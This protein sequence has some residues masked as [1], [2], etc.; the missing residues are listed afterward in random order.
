MSIVKLRP[1]VV[2]SFCHV[3][4]VFLGEFHQA[5]SLLM[6]DRWMEAFQ[7]LQSGLLEGSED[8]VQV[9]VEFLRSGLSDALDLEGMR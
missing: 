5:D 7:S 8:P 6:I 3:K 1:V 4:M 9:S 2:R